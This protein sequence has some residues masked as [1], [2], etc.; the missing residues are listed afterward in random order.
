MKGGKEEREGFDQQCLRKI[1][2]ATNILK[3]EEKIKG[4]G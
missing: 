3:I 4:N 1:L 2:R